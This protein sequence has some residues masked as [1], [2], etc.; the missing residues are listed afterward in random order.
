MK[1]NLYGFSHPVRETRTL[2][3][4]HTSKT[5]DGLNLKKSFWVFAYSPGDKTFMGFLYESTIY[6]LNLKIKPFCALLYYIIG[7]SRHLLI[8]LY[9]NLRGSYISWRNCINTSYILAT[10]VCSSEL[11]TK[12][13]NDNREAV[14]FFLNKFSTTHLWYKIIP[15]TYQC[16]FTND[17]GCLQSTIKVLSLNLNIEIIW[18]WIKFCPELQTVS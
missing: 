16:L 2:G 18:N 6:G 4:F 3:V 5:I 7:G 9:R 12:L 1:W 14:S 8:N 13:L 11:K 17:Q 10:K 15:C